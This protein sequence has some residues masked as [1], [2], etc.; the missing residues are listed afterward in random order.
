MSHADSTLRQRLDAL[1]EEFDQV[2]KRVRQ[3]SYE[4]TESGL[5]P[6][7]QLLDDLA[8]ARIS[9]LTFQADVRDLAT[10]LL[11]VEA[12][13]RDRMSTLAELRELLALISDE[14]TRRARAEDMRARAV[15]ALDRVLTL[16]HRDK[17]DSEALAN[18]LARARELRATIVA[19][20]PPAAHPE[21]EA[22]VDGTHPLAQLLALVAGR[23]H[24][25]D[26]RAASLMRAVTRAF[27]SQLAVAALLGKLH[28]RAE[29]AAA[30]SVAVDSLDGG[31]DHAARDDGPA[32]RI[33]A[34]LNS[35]PRDPAIPAPPPNGASTETWSVAGATGAATITPRPAFIA[36]PR[37]RPR[38]MTATK[39]DVVYAAIYLAAIAAAEFVSALVNP[40]WGV[41][42][43]IAILGGLLAEA[44]YR[45][46]PQQRAF[47]LSLTLAPLIRVVSLSLPLGYVPQ[48]WWYALASI[49]L[50]AAAFVLIRTI[51]LTHRQIALQLPSRR[52]WP[53]VALVAASGVVLGFIQ[54]LLLRPA[55]LIG[56]LAPGA[57]ALTA[58]ILLLGTG[59][60]EELLFRG[61]LQATAIEA[62]GTWP[63]IIYVS[64][65]FGALNIGHRSLV[66][67]AFAIG[68]ALY[69]SAVVRWTRTLVGVSLAH[70]L[71][72]ILLFIV[73]PLWQR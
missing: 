16:A 35:S 57:V 40:L 72:N 33:V 61:I 65:L 41:V 34:T 63:G 31:Q 22:L 25:T 6:S 60:L 68:V 42:A 11:G 27:G 58:V 46:C 30:D 54:Y 13:P 59:V 73:V 50:F 26:E 4:M 52:H 48:R 15:A 1:L 14:L 28:A 21:A 53:A 44:T 12:A 70:G 62:L 37:G 24:L 7:E 45:R 20:P 10:S 49:P 8:T 9:F 23:D 5:P 55:P 66:G 2:S 32:T 67:V 51:P 38:A 69:F 18:C 29:P 17:P 39:S 56:S 19:L 71:T 36:P 64:T 43:H 47:F 3:A